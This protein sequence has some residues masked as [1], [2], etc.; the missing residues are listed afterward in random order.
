MSR[1][2]TSLTGRKYPARYFQGL[3]KDMQRLRE[4]E[5]ELRREDSTPELSFTDRLVKT[6]P[7]SWTKAF[8][9]EFPDVPADLKVMAKVFGIPYKSLDMVFDKGL[10]AWASSGSRPGANAHQWAWARVYKFILIELGH[11]AMQP[12]DPDNHLHR[13]RA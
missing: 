10:A 1:H 2:Y 13:V 4:I 6:R 8:K 9:K 7:S 11:Y 3:S 5:L 12:R